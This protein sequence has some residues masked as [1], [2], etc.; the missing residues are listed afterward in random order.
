MGKKVI[1]IFLL[2]LFTVNLRSEDNEEASGKSS[3]DIYE[4]VS[5]LYEKR[6]YGSILK[7]LAFAEEKK[8]DWIKNPE[9]LALLSLIYSHAVYRNWHEGT[10][11]DELLKKAETFANKALKLGK[12]EYFGYKAMGNIYLLKGDRTKA[13]EMFQK[14][15]D[16]NQNDAELW[17]FYAC[18]SNGKITDRYSLAGQRIIRTLEVD[19]L[20]IWAKEDLIM[21]F[22]IE[23]KINKAEAITKDLIKN[24]PSYPH[25]PYFEAVILLR[26]GQKKEAKEK[27]DQFIKL[28]PGIRLIEILK[29]KMYD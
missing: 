19:P 25:I 3:A 14:A 27:F 23:N 12:E 9:Y 18:A 22:I 8:D 29:E 6:D 7:A 4:Q 13:L 5:S 15:T 11:R 24:N 16:I 20:F 17:Y 28:N 10:N 1:S 26:K 2:L 21:A